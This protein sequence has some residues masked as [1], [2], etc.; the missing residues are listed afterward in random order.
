M[1][2]TFLV[3]ILITCTKILPI[4]MT[5]IHFNF[6]QFYFYSKAPTLNDRKWNKLKGI[7]LTV[8]QYIII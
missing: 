5:L 6:V 3:Y 7:I 1:L 4:C 8:T 2:M